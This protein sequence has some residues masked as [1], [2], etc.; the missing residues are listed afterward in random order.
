MIELPHPPTPHCLGCIPTVA[1]S[2]P[3]RLSHPSMSTAFV[4]CHQPLHPSPKD[5]HAHLHTPS[6]RMPAAPSTLTQLRTATPVHILPLVTCRQPHRHS[7]QDCH[8]HP[9][10]PSGCMPTAPSTLAQGLPRP[11]QPLRPSH[12][13]CHAHPLTTDSLSCSCPSHKTVTPTTYRCPG[14]YSS[15]TC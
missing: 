10:T 4:V 7:P 3:V 1:S 11:Q 12:K 13:V 8:A 9:Q 5:C 15:V 2:L 6:G 14:H